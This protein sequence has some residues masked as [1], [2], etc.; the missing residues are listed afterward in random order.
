MF[1]SFWFE[2]SSICNPKV[3]WFPIP[4]NFINSKFSAS[5]YLR[6]KASYSGGQLSRRTHIFTFKEPNDSLKDLRQISESLSLSLGHIAISFVGIRG[7]IRYATARS[8]F[9][10][11][12]TSSLDL[13]RCL[14]FKI[15]VEKNYKT[16]YADQSNQS[17]T[18]KPLFSILLN[19]ER[20]VY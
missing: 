11:I 3:A 20:I 14:S 12:A 10:F 4:P 8:Y 5:K 17:T 9:S 2:R 7:Q 18:S 13:L 16:V 19:M 6:N 1:E 15:H